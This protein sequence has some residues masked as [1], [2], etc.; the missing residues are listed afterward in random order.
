MLRY[1]NLEKLEINEVSSN[2]EIISKGTCVMMIENE[3]VSKMNSLL[4]DAVKNLLADVNPDK[5]YNFNITVLTPEYQGLSEEDFESAVNCALSA[6]FNE[7]VNGKLGREREYRLDI[8]ENLKTE[9]NCSM[10][11]VK[12]AINYKTKLDRFQL[13]ISSRTLQYILV[14]GYDE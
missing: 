14:G 10:G 4:K 5:I 13:T 7:M 9:V 2:E 11:L 8:P 1:L 12:R 3:V 6:F